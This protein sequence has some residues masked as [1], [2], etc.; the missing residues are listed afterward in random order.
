MMEKLIDYF[1]DWMSGGG[2]FAYNNF[3]QSVFDED[4]FPVS[5]E[6]LDLEFFGNVSGDKIASPLVRKIG[7][8]AAL[9]SDSIIALQSV[10]NNI[11]GETFQR[12]LRT[13]Q[14]EYNPANNYDMSE[15]YSETG[16]VEY[17]K[18][19]TRT[20]NTNKRLTVSDTRT[21]NLTTTDSGTENET[22]TP[23]TTETRTPNT[24][25]TRTSGVYGFNSSS[26][27]N[28]DTSQTAVSG[29]DTTR[30]TG[31]ETT[32]KTVGNTRTENGTEE[33]STTSTE[34]NTGTVADADTGTD[35]TTKAHTLTRSGNIGVT[36]TQQMLQSERELW[37]WNFIRE[38]VFP[39]VDKV[40]TIQMY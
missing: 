15:H 22:Q 26:A 3:A 25:E 32:V 1:P 12:V 17:G 7:N 23:N 5:G 6:A 4:V 34:T 20:D 31:T 14:I 36:T 21:P 8:N 19:R 27:S 40:L 11:N 16:A 9:T 18:T 35:E 30:K 39:A 29:T 33:R 38:V 2:I 24:T 28:S 37:I 10:I 13:Y